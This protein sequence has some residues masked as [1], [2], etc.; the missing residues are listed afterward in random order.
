MIS[1]TISAAPS[2]LAAAAYNAGPSRARQWIRDFGDPR[3]GTDP[4]NW[5]ESIPFS[6]TRNYV[7]RVLEN[8]EVYR[9]RLSGQPTEIRLS[10]DLRRGRPN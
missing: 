4:V 9:N 10:E 1:S 5:I 8:T 3:A 2:I 6:E 7:Q